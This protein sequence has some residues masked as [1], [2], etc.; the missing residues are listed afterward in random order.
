MVAVEL[1]LQKPHFV[2]ISTSIPKIGQPTEKE[3]NNDIDINLIC[4][5]DKFMRPRPRDLSSDEN[6]C[7][8]NEL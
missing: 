2:S 4:S 7:A 3:Y 5:V 8:G 6:K 1:L